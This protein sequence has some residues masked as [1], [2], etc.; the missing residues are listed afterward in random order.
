MGGMCSNYYGTSLILVRYDAEKLKLLSF[1]ASLKNAWL[2]TLE[3]N[4]GH[5]W[6]AATGRQ[7][8]AKSV[9][10]PKVDGSLGRSNRG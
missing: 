1:A 10:L 4:A 8:N 7:D 5:I 9:N 3:K 6:F 2:V